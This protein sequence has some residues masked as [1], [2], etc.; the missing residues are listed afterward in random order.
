MANIR[1]DLDYP[2]YDG[3]NVTF[4]AP[5]DCTG[6][7]GLTVYYPGG[8]KTFTLCD[9]HGVDISGIG[10][11]FMKGVPVKAILD[12][13]NAKAFIQNGDN[14]S[15]LATMLNKISDSQHVAC[16]SYTG[17]GKNSPYAVT[18]NFDFTP[19]FLLVY[20]RHEWE[21]EN[22]GM[23]YIYDNYVFALFIGDV[24]FGVVHYH[25]WVGE[26]SYD[27]WTN[28]AVWGDNSVSFGHHYAPDETY[29][30]YSHYN[31]DI[32]GRTYYYVA[33]G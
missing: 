29:N 17:T 11:V 10:D 8:N 5:C 19:K 20:N 14:N 7:D 12:V 3:A 13:T 6:A 9:A 25:E 22:D 24:P 33:I 1:V 27:D 26:K 2:I 31:L 30:P 15:F 21:V 23:K 28:N 4:K 32:S 16:G 18:L